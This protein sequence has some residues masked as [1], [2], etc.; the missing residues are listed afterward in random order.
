[1]KAAAAWTE[2]QQ[3]RLAHLDNEMKEL[4]EELAAEKEANDTMG[5]LVEEQKKQLARRE[6]HIKAGRCRQT[7]EQMCCVSLRGQA[8]RAD[9]CCLFCLLRV[10]ARLCRS[11]GLRLW[12]QQRRSPRPVLHPERRTWTRRTWSTSTPES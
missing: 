11:C 12:P 4:Q 5:S 2:D 8:A 7:P 9:G 1:M 3:R 6:K 10:C